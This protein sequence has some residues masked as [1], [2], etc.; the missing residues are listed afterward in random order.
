MS[1]QI[2]TN[3][4][5]ELD[6]LKKIFNDLNSDFIQQI[7]Q[8]GIQIS[9]GIAYKFCYINMNSILNNLSNQTF[10]STCSN[11]VK[12]VNGMD[13]V[14]LDFL[15]QSIFNI[16][17][18]F[19]KFNV[20]I[21]FIFIYIS[22]TTISQNII[23]NKHKIENSLINDCEDIIIF[24]DLNLNNFYIQTITT[25]E[26]LSLSSE[27]RSDTENKIQSSNLNS[28]I[29][30]LNLFDCYILITNDDLNYIIKTEDWKNKYIVLSQYINL[31]Y[32]DELVEILNT[33]LIIKN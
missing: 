17:N 23:Y 7:I 1:Q 13:D 22:E 2:N 32:S 3:Q 30:F 24:K 9:G 10:H 19:R 15:K 4:R 25:Q 11:P 8:R 31:D 20:I 27:S 21:A 6:N 5:S 33:K 16:S 28:Y 14:F 26:S 18:Y 12:D 29:Q